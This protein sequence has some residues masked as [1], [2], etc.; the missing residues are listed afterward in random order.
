MNLS[1]NHQIVSTSSVN[2][3]WHGIDL[4]WAY[5]D[6]LPNI[7]RKTS[8]RQFAYDVLHDSLVRFALSKNPNRN[9]QPHAYLQVIIRNLLTDDY[10]TQT[11]FVQL[12][13]HADD[14]VDRSD[15]DKSSHYDQS[16]SPSAEHLL[17]IQQRIAALQTLINKLPDRCRE[18]F[19]LY[20]IEGV[21]Q[22]DIALQLGISLNMVERHVMRSMKDL[23]KASALIL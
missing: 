8:C 11:R 23:L 1:I 13:D 6:L 18:V 12:Q 20:R 10:R 17:D 16:F 21:A 14:E 4:G 7:Y 5:S 9:E 19:W 22:A 2:T 15:A 3:L